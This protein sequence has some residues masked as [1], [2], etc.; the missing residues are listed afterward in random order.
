M[1]EC[2]EQVVTVE[3]R[4]LEWLA[5]GTP[6]TPRRDGAKEMRLFTLIRSRLTKVETPEIL[7]P[8]GRFLSLADAL[9]EFKMVRD[10]SAQFAQERG[11]A[12]YS[13][14]VRH[15][16]LGVLNGA[17]LLQLIDGHA[18]RHADQIRELCE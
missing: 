12:L 10:R 16:L 9:A 5:N 2:I 18:R 3:G 14:G 4:Y 7:Q 8:R 15:P 6:I 17:E 11:E 13:V 1:L